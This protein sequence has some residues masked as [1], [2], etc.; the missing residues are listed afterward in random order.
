M[1]GIRKQACGGSV[2]KMQV[3]GVHGGGQRKGSRSK[4]CLSNVSV[5]GQGGTTGES[6]KRRMN[7]PNR[8]SNQ[9]EK[10]K[11]QPH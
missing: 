8:T 6:R 1:K 7:Q 11:R 5:D 2:E 9:S 4:V 3:R 10:E